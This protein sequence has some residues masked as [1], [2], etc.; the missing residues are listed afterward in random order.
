M[1]GSP[2]ESDLPEG[3]RIGGY[4]WSRQTIGRSNAGVFRLTGD[5]KPSLFLKIEEAGLFAEVAAE[6][7][8]L[9]WLAGQGIAC[10]AIIAFEHHAGRH[11]LLMTALPGQDLAST[12]ATDAASSVAIMA[13]ALRELHAI[14]AGSCPFDHR[15]QQRIAEAWARVEAGTVDESDFDDERQ[16]MTAA[17]ALAQ[18]AALKPASEDIVVTH[19]DACMPNF[20][21]ASKSFS[22]FV[23][24]GRLGLADRHQDLALACWSIRHNIGERWVQPFLDRY[25]FMG[26]DPSRLSYYRL[27]DE[28]F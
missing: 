9:R 10:A 22:G 16:G 13:D 1:P 25:G 4:R 19:G 24:C 26:V 8:R 5:N 14:D 18:L 11:W 23:D 6:E 21:A 12:G 15:L 3:L 27:L 7:A 28:F 20:V 17:E 2:F